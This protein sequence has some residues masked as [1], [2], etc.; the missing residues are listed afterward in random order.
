M[1]ISLHADSD[2]FISFECPYCGSLFKLSA[3]DLNDD[4]FPISELFCPYCGL[5][6]SFS[7]FLSKKAIEAAE[8]KVYNETIE[9]LNKEFGKMA[10]GLNRTKGLIRMNYKPIEKMPENDV[11][12]SDTVETFF[13]ASY[14]STR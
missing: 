12:D 11:Y 14:V 8:A 6:D 5:V 7:G 9:M 2:G 4:S 13:T 3:A 1:E 10:K